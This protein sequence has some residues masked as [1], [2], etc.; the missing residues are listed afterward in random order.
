MSR[1]ARRS[2]ALSVAWRKR[3][4]LKLSRQAHAVCR[5]RF[6]L[7]REDDDLRGSNRYVVGKIDDPV[8][9]YKSTS[10]AQIASTRRIWTMTFEDRCR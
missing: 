1:C 6:G 3:R 7:L 8:C 4:S 2:S 10:L 9:G 5:R